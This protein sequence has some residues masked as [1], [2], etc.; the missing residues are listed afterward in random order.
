M[1]DRRSIRCALAVAGLITPQIAMAQQGPLADETQVPAVPQDDDA[2]ASQGGRGDIIVTGSRIARRD[3]EA[4]SPITTLN[5]R[6]LETSGGVTVETA[7]N[8]LPQFAASA[9]SASNITNRSGQASANLRGLGPQRTLVLVDGR[10]TQPANPDGSADLNAIPDALIENVEVITGGASSTYGSDAVGG[11]V[12]FK[13]KRRFT[14]VQ[15]DSQLGLTSRGDGGSQNIK[16]IAGANLDDDRGNIVIALNYSHRDGIGN[17]QREFFKFS[18]VTTSFPQGTLKVDGSNLPTQTAV[19]TIFARY[20]VAPG[21]APRNREFGFNTDGTLFIGNPA[22][23]YRDPPLHTFVD[24]GKVLRYSGGRD[25]LLRTPLTR[26]G[27]FLRANYDVTDDINVYADLNVTQYSASTQVASAVLGGTGQADVLVPLSN[28]FI[29]ADL[30][31]L[32]ASR[33][34][35]D[36]PLSITRRL[37]ETGLKIVDF[38][39]E[40]YQATIGARGNLGVGDWTWD[41]YGS[42]GRTELETRENAPQL[43]SITT[44][45]N[46][47]GGGT[48]VCT[49]GF[50]AFGLTTLSPQCLDFIMRPTRNVTVVEQDSVEANFQGGLFD[51]P[52]G[53]VRIATGA[54]YR[55]NTFKFQPDEVFVVKDIVGRDATSPSAGSDEVGEVYL[56]AL[57]PLLHDLPLIRQLEL[58]AGYRYSNYRS[59]GGVH[60]YKADL[61]WQV[62]ESVRIRGGYSRAIRA[63]SVGELFSGR[64]EVRFTFPGASNVGYGDPC[65][66]RATTRTGANGAQVA[67]LCQ[68][69]GIPAAA[70]AFFQNQ[71]ARLIASTSGNPDLNEEVTDTI[72]AGIVWRPRFSSPLFSRL[73]LSVDYYRI[74]VK[75][76]I[77]SVTTQLALNKCFNL[78]GSNPSYSQDNYYCSL[79]TRSPTTGGI[80]SV[81]NPA[82]NLG[83]FRT[84]GID[85]QIDWKFGLDAIGLKDD[86]GSLQFTGVVNY[87]E[88]FEISTE[89]NAPFIDYAGT[90]GNSQI[91]PLSLSKPKWKLTSSVSY[92]VGSFQT[93]LRYRFIDAQDN[94]VNA[95]TSG[96]VPGVKAVSYLDLDFRVDVNDRF[97]FRGGVVNLT[98]VPPPQFGPQRSITDVTTYD[99][100]GRRFYIGVRTSF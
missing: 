23:N 64:S 94:A 28:P 89:A 42:K 26:Y 44:L 2:E 91:D 37:S 11:V 36:A 53:G 77:G 31:E 39:Y 74:N 30:R 57:V 41:V 59:V 33:A 78:D 9:G 21:T 68:A 99:V 5:A 92:S 70:N 34:D 7:L 88:K 12:N 60:T 50:D 79:I 97:Q 10:R 47:P 54:A 8:Q 35:P 66:V 76:A 43:S 13:L 56:E 45:L 40:I 51:L 72:S 1:L 38:N 75:D 65:D 69:Q 18:G 96:T 20:G 16:F 95:G 81:E 62:F 67:A 80:D 4:T 83:G 58:N 90:N 71:N 86:W 14:G 93:T 24:D 46:A 6:S 22:I 63:P 73:S 25:Y 55:R 48:G 3:F 49:G 100:E 27:G 32:A 87:L 82:L 98:D 61:D 29:P 85:A 52:A 17:N 84:S 15:L 19:N